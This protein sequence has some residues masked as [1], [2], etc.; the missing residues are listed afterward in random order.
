MENAGVHSGDATLI[1]PPQTISEEDIAQVGCNKWAW[2]STCCLVLTFRF[3]TFSMA[4][5]CN[6]IGVADHVLPRAPVAFGVINV[7]GADHVLPRACVQG[8]KKF[9]CTVVYKM[10]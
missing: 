6:G 3:T 2:L 4:G 7:G 5:C 9:L 10:V 8:N 1:L